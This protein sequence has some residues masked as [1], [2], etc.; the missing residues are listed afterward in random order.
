M[1]VARW[2]IYDIADE[3]M[4]SPSVIQRAL[5]VGD[6]GAIMDELSVINHL[7]CRLMDLSKTGG[8]V[9]PWPEYRKV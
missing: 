2:D 7:A 4:D 6:H 9:G 3:L 5:S 1:D 8:E